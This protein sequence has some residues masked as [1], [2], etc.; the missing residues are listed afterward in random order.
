MVPPYFEL[1]QI[2]FEFAISN[3]TEQDFSTAWS[4]G[5][6]M[7]TARTQPATDEELKGH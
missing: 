2:Q 1:E 3:Q 6:T 5:R 7:N 4:E